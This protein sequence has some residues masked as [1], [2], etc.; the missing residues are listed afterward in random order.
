MKFCL[1]FQLVVRVTVNA[2]SLKHASIENAKILARSKDVE[3]MLNVVLEITGLNV[4]V[5]HNISEI[6]T[7]FVENQNA[8]QI[9][10]VILH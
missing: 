4:P 2:L 5:Y 3:S 9:Q 10:I 1:I 8:L 6:L 7:I